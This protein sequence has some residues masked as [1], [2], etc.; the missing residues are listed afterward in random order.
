MAHAPEDPY[1]VLGVPS[2]ASQDEIS[3]AYRRLVREHHPDLHPSD[4]AKPTEPQPSATTQPLRR[5]LDA[6]A[7]LR[8]PV[9]RAEYDRAHGSHAAPRTEPRWSTPYFQDPQAYIRDARPGES[10]WVGPVRFDAAPT[11]H[12]GDEYAIFDDL[13]DLIFRH[14]RLR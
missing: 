10:V 7:L 1:T 9:S 5:V 11:R 12:R 3:R 13:L 4:P 6:Y 8:D 14:F 2:T